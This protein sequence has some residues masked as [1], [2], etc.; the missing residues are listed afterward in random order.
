MVLNSSTFLPKKGEYLSDSKEILSPLPNHKHLLRGKHGTTQTIGTPL[1]ALWVSCSSR[2][3]P[4]IRDQ[5]QVPGLAVPD[6]SKEG[7]PWDNSHPCLADPSINLQVGFQEKAKSH[8]R[9]RVLLGKEP[10]AFLD[11]ISQFVQSHSTTFILQQDSVSLDLI[12]DCYHSLQNYPVKK[13]VYKVIFHLCLWDN[14]KTEVSMV[15]CQIFP[16]F[17][18][19]LFSFICRGICLNA[20][21]FFKWKKTAFVWITICLNN[22]LKWSLTR[23]SITLLSPT[24]FISSP[25]HHVSSQPR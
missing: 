18:A 23:G 4:K 12:T 9:I 8:W 14:N 20:N 7:N 16:P 2:H 24:C 10:L 11:K 22:F 15:W 6:F 1:W 5:L 19:T 3:L 13:Y 25:F 21:Y 17:F